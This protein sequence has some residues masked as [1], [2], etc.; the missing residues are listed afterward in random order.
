MQIID[1]KITL[2]RQLVSEDKLD[3]VWGIINYGEWVPVRYKDEILLLSNRYS[4]WQGD[5]RKGL[6]PP[7]SERISV[8]YSVLLILSEIEEGFSRI[9]GGEYQ[10]R[11]MLL[12]QVEGTVV[13]KAE[14]H[15]IFLRSLELSE[16]ISRLRRTTPILYANAILGFLEVVGKYLS[17]N[18]LLDSSSRIRRKFRVVNASNAIMVILELEKIFLA[19]KPKISKLCL[20][21]NEGML[22]LCLSKT[23]INE[24]NSA[25]ID[26]N[27][28][29]PSLLEVNQ[30]M[31]ETN[32]CGIIYPYWAQDY[33]LK[34]EIVKET[35]GEIN[36]IH[37]EYKGYLAAAIG[38][39]FIGLSA[40]LLSILIS[41]S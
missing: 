27:I 32:I 18:K 14:N 2:V 10:E 1:E 26:L 22:K 41:D 24:F 37:K 34:K 11:I 4:H 6:N 29:R 39:V 35:E 40:W 33:N 20:N 38:G 31:F 19:N 13:K 25:I 15:L 28:E 36:N 12:Q 9:A 21:S 8:I 7:E 5:R 30:S 17:D 23:E 16:R 3:E